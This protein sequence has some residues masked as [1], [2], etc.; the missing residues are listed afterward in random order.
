[1]TKP[2]GVVSTKIRFILEAIRHLRLSVEASAIERVEK[3]V[4]KKT[5][6][7]KAIVWI[8]L[9]KYITLLLNMSMTLR[10]KAL[11]RKG[12]DMSHVYIYF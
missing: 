4:R 11:L 2:K 5:N 3:A 1:M 7:L 8:G 10:C 12:I 6:T 9:C